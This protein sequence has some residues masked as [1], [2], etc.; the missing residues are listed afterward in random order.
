MSET[1]PGGIYLQNDVLVDCEGKPIDPKNL[2]GVHGRLLAGV[3]DGKIGYLK[4]S[5]EQKQQINA[6][7]Q[8][9]ADEAEL[10]QQPTQLAELGKLLEKASRVVPAKPH[11]QQSGEVN[12]G[13]TTQQITESFE[14]SGGKK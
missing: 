2:E 14:R 10:E 12:L 3:P 4:L 13:A 7:R 1:I 9:K 11:S 8:R 6:E 5:G